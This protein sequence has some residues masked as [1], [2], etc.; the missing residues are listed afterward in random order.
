M[1]SL[2][3]L[4]AERRAAHRRR[5]PGPTRGP[6][7]R[8]SGCGPPRSGLPLHRRTGTPI[9]PMSPLIKLIWFRE[10]EPA[11]V[12][13]VRALGRHQGVRAVAAGRRPGD[14]PFGRLGHR[15]DGH[16]HAGAGTPRRCGWPASPPTSCPQL[17]PTTHV[18]PALTADAAAGR[19]GCRRDTP[20][21]VGAGDG[22]LANLGLGRRP[23][24]VV[25]PARSARAA[26]CGSWS[27]RPGVDPLGGVF[28]YALTESR[29][30]V[31][32]AINNGG[33]VLD[34]AADALAP[35]LVG[36]RRGPVRGAA[37][38]GRHARRPAAAGCSCCR[39]C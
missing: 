37:R 36:D 23:P 6:A 39:T 16:P 27:S 3:G 8:P 4:D 35:D 38:P 26:R 17:V 24:G 19:S 32:G 1:H 15:A 18:L 9:H 34:W 11:L 5:S 28:C 10:Q 25:P 29:W 22:P 31:G 13:E 30:V 21:V 14:G 7:P 12:R 20:V 2:I 33:I